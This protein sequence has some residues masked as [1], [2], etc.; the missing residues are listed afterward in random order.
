MFIALKTH[1]WAYPALEVMHLVGIA[2]L[3]GNLIA[4]ELRTWGAVPRIDVRDLAKL[5]LSI[6]VTGFSIAAASGLLLFASQAEELIANRAFLAKM[7]LIM[8]AGGNAAWF[9]ARGS[10]SKLDSVAKMQTLVSGLIWIAAIAAGRWIA[11]I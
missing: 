8:I 1:P 10:L 11:Y 7:G 6:A 9:H 3:V 4:F 5:S 2:L